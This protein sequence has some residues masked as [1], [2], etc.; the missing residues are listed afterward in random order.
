M[1]PIQSI[2]YILESIIKHGNN[3]NNKGNVDWYTNTIQANIDWHHSI[4]ETPI[5]G[6]MF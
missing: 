6:C 1:K 2:V 3:N 4:Y 5:K